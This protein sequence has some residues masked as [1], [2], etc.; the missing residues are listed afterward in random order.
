MFFCKKIPFRP[1]FFEK[2]LEMASYT[3]AQKSPKFSKNSEQFY[4]FTNFPRHPL[5]M[6]QAIHSS[7]T[8]PMCHHEYDEWLDSQQI[9]IHCLNWSPTS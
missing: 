6:I 4:I 5:P 8:L 2:I 7:K 9:R 3:Q 1:K